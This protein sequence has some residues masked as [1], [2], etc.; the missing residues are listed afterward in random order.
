MK[1]VFFLQHTKTKWCLLLALFLQEPLLCMHSMLPLFLLKQLDA[2]PW[3]IAFLTMALPAVSIFSF[4][5]ASILKEHPKWQRSNLILATLLAP[6][7]YCFSIFCSYTHYFIVASCFFMLF[8]RG[9]NP[10]LMEILRMQFSKEERSHLYST[11]Y[12]IG[13]AIE[14]VFGS[15][16][17]VFLSWHP[18]WWKALFFVF[19]LLYA[20]S[21]FFYKKIP[22][23][24]QESVSLPRP[25]GSLWE[26]LITPWT[27]S[28]T[29]LR[30]K[31]QFRFF[32]IGFFLGGFGLMITR[33]SIEMVVAGLSLSYM[34]L[35]LCRTVLKALGILLSAKLWSQV[36]CRRK[37]L[38]T[39][40][41]VLAC[42]LLF[43]LLMG[44][45]SSF[46]E[47]LFAAYF[48][49]GFAQSGSH[50]VWNLSG[51]LVAEKESSTPYS[52]VNVLAVGV[53]G[54][55]APLL[56]ACTAKYLGLYETLYIGGIFILFGALYFR[57][58]AKEE[59][60]PLQGS[61]IS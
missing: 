53:R 34:Q 37:V 44:C 57:T 54:I 50:L 58:K 23:N 15:L 39:S 4:Y 3:H 18:E 41:A 7:L 47:M 13:F 21:I 10:A 14:M 32:Q 29:L 30:K 51:T 48:F 20:C 22:G 36:L 40:Y 56:G 60:R 5:W 27:S 12:K 16:I 61:Y 38:L 25:S 28:F 17:G 1:S 35:F 46:P 43:Y 49:Y 19:G 55:V 24:W 52:A 26:R 2:T 42:F 31:Q 45:T 8:W 6:L 33:P 9:G 11:L 59:E